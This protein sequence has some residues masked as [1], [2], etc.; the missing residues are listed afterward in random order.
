[1]TIDVSYLAELQR[2][3]P[4]QVH[5]ALAEDL[6]GEADAKHDI[7]ASLIP[8]EARAE[9]RLITREAGVICGVAWVNE[10]FR[11]LAHPTYGAVTIDWQVADGE[12]VEPDQVLCYLRGPARA[13]LT[14]ERTAMNFLQTLSATATVVAQAVQCLA[15]TQTQLLDTRK[16][17]PGLRLGQKYAVR[18]GG[19]HNHRI[20]LADAFLI[21]ENHI[22]ACGGIDAAVATARANFP[23]R[24]VEV[25]T[26]SLA[27]LEQAL[28][29]GADVI[30]LD[31]F[32]LD[33]IAK[34][35]TITAGRAKL[36]VSG[37]ITPAKLVDYA[38][39]GVDY[40]SSGALTKHV[41]AL[42][43]SMRITT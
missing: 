24:W 36:E 39:C 28:A 25:E 38:R 7:T 33:D 41:Q 5:A 19:G 42:D 37:N 14:G 17:I 16:T 20:G 27:E 34:A 29:A 23:G 35:V 40:I 3:I 26:E 15:G 18:C 2:T 6:G 9:A 30:M 32:T 31:N 12:T 11:Q 4:A 13:L 21:K 1:M 22:A 8:A 10:V 43:L